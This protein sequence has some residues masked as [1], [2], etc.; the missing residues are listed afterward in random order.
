MSDGKLVKME[1]DYSNTVDQALPECQEMARVRN[2][3]QY[4]ILTLSIQTGN[5]KG[6]FDKLLSVEKLTRTVSTSYK[7]Y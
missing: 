5:V 2:D 1:V 3:D 6:A 7:H 4:I